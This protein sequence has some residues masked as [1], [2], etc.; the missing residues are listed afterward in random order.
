MSDLRKRKVFGKCPK[1]FGHKGIYG[2]S[3]T[4]HPA[5]LPCPRCDA[6]GEVDI[7]DLIPDVIQEYPKPKDNE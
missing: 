2:R 1:C 6:T 7:S 4:G 5:T 3:P